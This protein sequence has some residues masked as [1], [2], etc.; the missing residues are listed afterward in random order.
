MNKNHISENQ[1]SVA[2]PMITYP[3][4]LLTT[5]QQYKMHFL[6]MILLLAACIAALTIIVTNPETTVGGTDNWWPIVLNV[7][8][9]RG[10]TSCQTQYFPFCASADQSTAS[11]EPLPILVFAAFTTISKS[12][13][14]A[15]IIQLVIF[16]AMLVGLYLFAETF[17]NVETA[18][19]ATLLCTLYIPIYRLIPQVSGDMLATACTM[20]AMYFVARGL[21]TDALMNWAFAGLFFGAG[22]L[23]RSVVLFVVLLLAI[24]LVP[25]RQVIASFSFRWFRRS[26]VLLLVVSLT[27]MPWIV[28]NYYVFGHVVIGT[29]LSGYNVYRHNSVLLDNNFLRYSNPADAKRAVE[30]LLNQRQDLRGTENE[31]EMNRVFAEES[32]KI[33]LAHPD[34]YIMLYFYRLLPLWFDI[35]IDDAYNQQPGLV[36]VLIIV[37]QAILLTLGLSG[38]WLLGRR[39]WVLWLPLVT[40]M[41]MH[42]G[43]V[44]RLRFVNVVM[45][46]LLIGAAYALTSI[47]LWIADRR[48]RT[49]NLKMR[50]TSE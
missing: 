34:R 2:E 16:M 10:F 13:V 50:T 37:Q 4:G 6:A 7:A 30:S 29:T 33:I 40:V 48:S 12:L 11:R 24:V 21:R 46:L 19:I 44:A 14:F 22:A 20:W 43:V 23:S 1:K 49:A 39:G 31:Y 36:E 27:L 9:G 8:E 18:L 5:L 41:V 15:S 42:M 28:R 38:F 3:D 17:V 32:R 26:A 25:W 45:P 47:G 35:G